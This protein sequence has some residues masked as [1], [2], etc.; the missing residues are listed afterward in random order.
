MIDV[1]R[2]ICD[3]R[4]KRGLSQAKLAKLVGVT[5][6]HINDLE[7]GNGAPSLELLERLCDAFDLELV[8]QPK[9]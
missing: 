5:Q 6:Q 4:A 2:M 9:K 3:E 7:H 1:K 8:I